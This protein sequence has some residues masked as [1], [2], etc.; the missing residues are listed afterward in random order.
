M[1]ILLL[2][3][4]SN[5]H[6]T[7]ACGLRTMGHEVTVV[8]SGDKFKSYQRDIN[9]VRNNHSFSESVKYFLDVLFHFS[10]FK[11]YDVVQL[12]NP[13]FLELKSKRIMT[14]FDYLKRNNRKVF[15]GAFGNDYYWV[16]ACLEKR[17]FRYSE[18][19][20]PGQDKLLEITQ[21][22]KNEWIDSELELLNKHIAEKA[23]GIVS[24]LY[25][26]QVSYQEVY[27]DKLKF[28]P[29]PINPDE[30]DYVER[31]CAARKVK[32]F[33]GI[34]KDRSKV[35]GTDVMLS[36]LKRI[37]EKFPEECTMTVAESVP[38]SEYVRLMDECD[39]ILDQLYSYTP[40]MNALAAMS[41]GLVAVTGGEPESYKILGETE[42]R[43]IVNVLP[44]EEDVF[45]KL[46]YLV[47]H[48]DEISI[49][50]RQSRLYVERH[51]DY[52]KVARQYLDFWTKR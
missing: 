51:H 43:P 27:S 13:V 19:D 23:D 16:R 15:L 18:F 47:N 9:L 12:I 5:L 29:L 8:S 46:A 2:G 44:T 6:W 17:L 45:Q 35:K 37:V 22:I 21:K 48:K 33:I 38:Y 28:I 39:V 4:Y 1:K 20:I 14:A 3:E 50:S 52:R 49:L 10:K 32:F 40:A 41:Q 31:N 25:E 11:G 30:V 24:C 7:L 26:Y 42:L 34:Q 36:A